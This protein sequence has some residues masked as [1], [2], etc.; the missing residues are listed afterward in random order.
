MRGRWLTIGC[1]PIMLLVTDVSIAGE[2]AGKLE[3]VDWE[4]VTLRDLDNNKRVVRVDIHNR[5]EAASYLGKTV[6]V[7]WQDEDGGC[8]AVQFRSAR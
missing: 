5:R 7:E 8:R 1:V 2:F 3:R 4:T 6:T